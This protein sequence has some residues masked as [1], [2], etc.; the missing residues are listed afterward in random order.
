MTETST[1]IPKESMVEIAK[2]IDRMML[3]PRRHT[4]DQSMANCH[5]QFTY[6]CMKAST[7]DNATVCDF[8]TTL[9]AIETSAELKMRGIRNEILT[10][11][12]VVSQDQNSFLPSAVEGYLFDSIDS[13]VFVRNE[14]FVPTD[15]KKIR[16][17]LIHLRPLHD[18]FVLR[19][20]G[21]NPQSNIQLSM[22]DCAIITGLFT[23]FGCALGM[24][25]G[26][27]RSN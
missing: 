26:R 11:M 4:V 20:S 5:E 12:K 13:P 21:H 6:R 9:E 7:S 2:V 24:I 19:N 17:G 22:Y 27:R 3:F 16:V 18:Y 1:F 25:L 14:S 10:T 23:G 8:Q 15:P